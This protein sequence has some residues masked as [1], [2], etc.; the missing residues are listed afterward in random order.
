M[1]CEARRYTQAPPYSQIP[2]YA[3]RAAARSWWARRK[4]V[5][6]E[7]IVFPDEGHGFRSRRNRVTASEAYV[8]FLNAHLRG[9]P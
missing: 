6:V 2:P 8:K 4:K 5:P 7:Y 9:A 3:E 1:L